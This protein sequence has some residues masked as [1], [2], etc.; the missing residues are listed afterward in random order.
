MDRP[1]AILTFIFVLTGLFHTQVSSIWCWWFL[2]DLNCSSMLQWVCT[3]WGGMEYWVAHKLFSWMFYYVGLWGFVGT[4]L[5]W[6]EDKYLAGLLQKFVGT[7][8]NIFGAVVSFIVS[9]I[10]MEWLGNILGLYQFFD[11]LYTLT[12]A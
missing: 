8:N 2:D 9:F 5:W 11:Y 10:L 7:I 1:K 12:H 4:I 3:M 6:V